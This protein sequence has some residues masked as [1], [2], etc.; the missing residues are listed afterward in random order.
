MTT[1]LTDDTVLNLD[2][3]RDLMAA[4]IREAYSSSSPTGTGP[5]FT[6]LEVA[7]AVID[8][9]IWLQSQ[10]SPVK[11]YWYS[12]DGE[13]EM[14][15]IGSADIV[16]G[17][18]DD[19]WSRVLTRLNARL[20]ESDNKLRYFGGRRFDGDDCP[21]DS[22][23]VGFGSYRFILPQV[24]LLRRS[25]KTVLAC[26]LAPLENDFAAN[27]LLEELRVMVPPV[28]I[29]DGIL[30]E[31][32]HRSD[33][34]S[35]QEWLARVR[36][37]CESF[38]STE[39]QKLVLA[40][41][42]S[43]VLSDPP[44]PTGLLRRLASTGSGC[45]RFCFQIEQHSA[46]IGAS[47]EL[48]YRRQ[49]QRVR[50][51]AMAGTRPR[52]NSLNE[53]R[54]LERQLLTSPKELAEQQFVAGHVRETLQ[55]L[56]A[57]DVREHGPEVLKLSTVQHLVTRFESSLAAGITDDDL[58]SALP[59]T[60]AVGGWPIEPALKEISRFELF[61]RGWYAGPVGWISDRESEFAV[62]IRSGLVAG[63]KIHLYTGAGIVP[64]STPESEWQELQSKLAGFTGIWTE[65][66]SPG[67]SV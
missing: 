9:L 63:E 21:A 40:R 14:A 16:T 6:R 44:D 11:T 60:P 43:L 45:F 4:R 1:I 46:L 12:R 37:V 34:P 31:V 47:P 48:L 33:C 38:G 3:A 17:G 42:T 18:A 29:P 55:Q 23:W 41:Q 19:D 15:G 8:P 32:L 26:N 51:E 57:E 53:D 13:F 54:A 49:E 27:G 52:G 25:D 59:P 62:A 67:L 65:V 66:C 50:S 35:R 36:S 30:P 24:E 5:D 20:T 39:M 28:V 10:Q 22:P 7:V 56:A 61:D 58:L 2:Q 64:G